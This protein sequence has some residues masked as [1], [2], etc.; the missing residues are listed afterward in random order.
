MMNGMIQYTHTRT[1]KYVHVCPGNLQFAPFHSRAL[2]D[3]QSETYE[4]LS[5]QLYTYN[6]HSSINVHSTFIKSVCSFLG[7]SKSSSSMT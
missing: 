5:V 3:K 4:L 1:H 2:F 6:L 7:Q